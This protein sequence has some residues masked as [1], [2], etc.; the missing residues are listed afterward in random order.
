MLRRK[1]GSWYSWKPNG[2][3]G[4]EERVEKKKEGKKDGSHFASVS[5]CLRRNALDLVDY[6]ISIRWR[7]QTSWKDTQGIMWSK[8]TQ[9][10]MVYGVSRVLPEVHIKYDWKTCTCMSLH[11]YSISGRKHG[12]WQ[13]PKNNAKKW[14]NDSLFMAFSF[15]YLNFLACAHL[16]FLFNNN[17][18]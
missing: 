1:D 4:G 3:R 13:G 11:V 9:H 10:T 6:S 12:Y 7:N 15:L 5:Q 8:K 17:N 14:E 18:K 2:V 16:L